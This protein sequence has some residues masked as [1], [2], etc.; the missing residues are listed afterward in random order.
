MIPLGT[1]TI[2]CFYGR[3][4]IEEE[5]E[6]LKFKIGAKSFYQTNSRQATN[7]IG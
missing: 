1:K 5:M 6:G 7:S 2:H 3:E 4:Y